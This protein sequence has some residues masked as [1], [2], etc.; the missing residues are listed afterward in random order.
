M[1]VLGDTFVWIEGVSRA[2]QQQDVGETGA[3]RGRNRAAGPVE[4]KQKRSTRSYLAHVRSRTASDSMVPFG[5]ALI[6]CQSMYHSHWRL[7]AT[8]VCRGIIIEQAVPPLIIPRSE[9]HTSELQ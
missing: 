2:C 6:T 4:T 1:N 3:Q 8:Q 7:S 5:V 9:E